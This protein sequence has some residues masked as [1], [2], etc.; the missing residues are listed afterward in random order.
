MVVKKIFNLFILSFFFLVSAYSQDNKSKLEVT[1]IANEG[2]LIESGNGKVL[3]D[4]LFGGIKGDWCEQPSDSVT[5]LMLNGTSP[6]DNIDAVLVTHKH[7]DHFNES[8]TINFLK[9]NPGTILICPEQVNEKLKN[10]IDYSK[11]YDRIKF[12]TPDNIYDT[13]LFFED[14]GIR[15]MRFKHGSYIETDSSTG[16]TYDL[17]KDTE[18]FGYL[19]GLNGYNVFHGGD[20]NYSDKERFMEYKLSEQEIDIA[21]FDRMFLRKEGMEII[22]SLNTKKLIFMHIEPKKR[23]YYKSVIKDIPEILIFDRPL[24]KYSY[25]KQE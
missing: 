4:A 14:I 23:E 6:F 22:N 16:I 17:H 9:N 3:I 18:N 8:L 20:C 11:L 1:Y 12:L 15:V 21:F 24:E 2:F 10:N 5:D 19:I 25:E 13:I 7:S